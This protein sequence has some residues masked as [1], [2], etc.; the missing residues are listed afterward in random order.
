MK[1]KCPLKIGELYTT[2][3]QTM[4]FDNKFN[5]ANI[6]SN[7]ILLLIDTCYNNS[8]RMW[9]LY[10]LYQNKILSAG[11]RMVCH[12]LKEYFEKTIVEET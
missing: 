5:V 8:E 1:V 7:E 12:S 11:N 4:L 10:F 6:K 3:T 9:I 2:K